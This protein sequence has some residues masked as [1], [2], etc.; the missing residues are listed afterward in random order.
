[1]LIHLF[2]LALQLVLTFRHASA[3]VPASP[4]NIT[5]DA[6]AAGLNVTD[7]SKLYLQWYPNG[8]Y[9]QNVSFQIVGTDSQ[10]VSKG[11]LVHFSEIIANN[12]TPPTNTPWIALVSCDFNATDM[13]TDIDIFTLARDKG[14]VAALLYSLYSQA[15]IINPEYADPD[16]F[17]QVFDIFSTQSRI[18]ANLIEAQFDASTMNR[19]LF[20][21]YNSSRLND[22]YK[23]IQTTIEF[24]YPSAPGYMFAV[25]QAYNAT[26]PLLSGTGGNNGGAGPSGNPGSSPNT[27]LAMIILYAITGCVSALFCV[28]IISGAIRAIRHPERY[29]PRARMGEDGTMPQSRARGLTRA[30]L[31]TFP[32]VK[33]GSSAQ[34]NDA[35]VLRTTPKDVEEQ[36]SSNESEPHPTNPT[37]ADPPARNGDIEVRDGSTQN[38]LA[39]EVSD[40][41]G[42]DVTVQ[43]QSPPQLNPTAAEQRPSSSGAGGSQAGPSSRTASSSGSPPTRQDVSPESMG[44]EICP[45]CIVEFEEGDDLRVL[46]CEGKHRFHQTCVDPW[47][48]ELSSMCP[49]CRQDFQTLENILSGS[50]EDDNPLDQLDQQRPASPRQGREGHH[51][52][53]FSRYLRF[54]HRRR[55]QRQQEEHDPTDPYM[56]TAP[57]TSMY[58]GV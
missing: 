41:I 51:H 40:A 57:E 31:D 53:R 35:Y 47:L 30:I 21:G 9:F 37:P 52:N 6:I 44:R 18:S 11:A 3:Y 46:P 33:F 32:V 55:D 4:T 24:G 7:V 1:M 39:K 14:A 12:D 17:D 2:A 48:L 56:P 29:G 10:G 16:H 34:T 43:N 13:S 19:Q 22:S 58:S 28:V 26:V 50:T 5:E 15:C 25:L 45:I 54:A 27:T 20:S 49:L 38:T 23:D 42:P 8:S 36:R